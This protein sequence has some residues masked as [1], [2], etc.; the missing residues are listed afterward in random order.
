MTVK[1]VLI[2][3]DIKDFHDI[4]GTLDSIDCKK[5]KDN[6]ETLDHNFLDLTRSS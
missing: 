6:L 1:T 5:I 3:K 2:S 4:L